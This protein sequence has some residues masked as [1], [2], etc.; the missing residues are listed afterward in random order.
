MKIIEYSKNIAAEFVGKIGTEDN[1]SISELISSEIEEISGG[2]LHIRKL[3]Q[4]IN[5]PDT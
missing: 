4:I 5:S 1:S 3:P 2:L